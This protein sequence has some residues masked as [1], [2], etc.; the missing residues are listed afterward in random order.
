VKKYILTYCL[1][2]CTFLGFTQKQANIW[3]FGYHVGVDFNQTPPKAIINGQAASAEGT[4][5]ISDKNGKL[6]FYTNGLVIMNR[7]HLLMKNG[8]SLAGSVSSTNNCVIVPQPG[9]DSIYYVF[10]T[11]AAN[12]DIQDFQYNIV[13]IKGDGGLGEVLPNATNIVVEG[14]IFEKLAAIK[15]CN[16]R[17]TWIVIHKWNTDEYHAF[18]LT[19]TGFNNTP[20]ISHSGLV[21][22]GD[23]LNELGTLK[24]SADGKKMAAV[25]SF[26]N[27]V[28]ELMDFDNTTGLLSS[29]IVIHPTP[30]PVSFGVGAY[31]AA[32]SPDGRLLYV[33]SNNAYDDA[34]PDTSKLYQFDITSNNIATITASKQVIHQ[35][36]NVTMGALQTGPDL[37]IYMASFNTNFLSVI[38]NPDI[39]GAGCNFNLKQI[40]YSAF[41]KEQ[42]QYGLPTFVQ[43]YFDTTGN[44]Y[45]FSRSGNCTDLNINF[46]INRLNGIDSVK[47]DFGDLGKSQALQPTHTYAAAGFYDVQLIV[48][49]IDCSGLNDTVVRKI[50]IAGTN[51]FLGADTSSC[52]VLTMQIG[53]QDIFGVNYLWN[54]GA[55]DSIINTTGFGDYWLELEQNGCKMRDTIKVTERPKPTVS[56][57]ADTSIC[58][59][60][61]AVLRTVSSNYDTYM[62][63]TGATTPSI[64]VNQIGNYY[65]TVTQKSCEASD[66]I[67]VLPGDCDI[68]IPSAF[69]P[70]KDNLNETFGVVDYSSVQYFSL[71]IYSKWGQ[72]I[73][74][75]NDINQKWDGTYKGKNMPNGSYLWMLNYTNN[76]GRKFYDQGTVMLIR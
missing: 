13:N 38:N 17:D 33:T 51:E 10:T 1:T 22:S 21:I 67:N 9:N 18:L 45:D 40:D 62:W 53:V 66:T 71:Q 54:S 60:K 58:K 75:T 23:E 7:Q 4:A 26:G 35:I 15:H 43:S 63:N 30:G 14:K 37:K 34:S 56:L 72:M 6:L 12:E 50:W 55:N 59:Y 8:G 68:Y 25:H 27:N 46:K 2:L 42:V 31:G 39:Y 48:Y 20:V 49:K 57:G 28:V 76:R 44:P 5:V 19:A 64:L 29:P 61:P 73:F 41:G 47:W 24:F 36:R 74:S 16:N 52:N 3:Y 32:F 11:G 70:N 69:T 65:V